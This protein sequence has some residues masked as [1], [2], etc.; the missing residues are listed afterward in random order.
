MIA[1]LNEEEYDIYQW[2]LRRAERTQRYS[3]NKSEQFRRVLKEI[4]KMLKNEAAANF[5]M[6]CLD[7]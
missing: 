5:Y 2:V 6:N 1:R 4:H 7:V 3:A